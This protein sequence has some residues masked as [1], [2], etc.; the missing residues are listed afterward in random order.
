MRLGAE[1]VIYDQ[2]DFAVELDFM[3]SFNTNGSTNA[4]A[5]N[6]N[7]KNAFDRQFFGIPAPTDVWIGMHEIP[8]IGNMRIGNVKAPNGLEH[9]TS[10]RFLD[11]M[12]RS[13]NQDLFVGRFNNCLLYTSDA[14]DE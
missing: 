9:T 14:A 13:L 2:F 3:N 1:G 7:L 11:F 6:N 12:E 4:F 8:F 10:S 5:P